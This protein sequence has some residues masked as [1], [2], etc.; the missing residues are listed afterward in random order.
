MSREN[1]SRLHD[2]DEAAQALGDLALSTGRPAMQQQVAHQHD[3]G[4]EPGE[5]V[6][7]GESSV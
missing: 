2:E 4:E 7:P 3:N 6:N 5:D 1:R